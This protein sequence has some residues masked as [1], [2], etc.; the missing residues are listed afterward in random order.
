MFVFSANSNLVKPEINQNT[1]QQIDIL[2]MV[3]NYANYSNPFFSFGNNL[4]Q[5]NWAMQ[6][7]N[8]FYQ[9][10]SWPYVYHFDGKKG[11]GFFDLKHDSLMHKNE[12]ENIKLKLKIE[13][14]DSNVK[15]IIQQ[16]NFDLINNKTTE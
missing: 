15:C 16:Y 6:L 11:I 2:P 1:I 5:T 9:Y 3:L 12:I 8:G 13:N 4:N 7:T 14:L 10:I